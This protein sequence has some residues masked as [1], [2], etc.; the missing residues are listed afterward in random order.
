MKK[1]T[2][3]LLSL[4]LFAGLIPCA[5]RAEAATVKVVTTI[6][7]I[8]D[9]VRQIAGDSG[10][11][12]PVMLL[13]NG[14]DLHSYQPSA[15]DILAISGANLFVYVGGE[16][17]G[18]VEGVLESAMNPSLISVSLTEAMG[19][20]LKEEEIVEGM[21]HEHDHDHDHDHEHEEDEDHDHE[22]E[23][24]DH[25]EHDHDEDHD[26]DHDHEEEEEYDEHVWLSLRNAA[27]LVNA[28]A[29]AL[30]AAD[31][32]GADAYKANADAYTGKL[33]ALDAEYTEAVNAAAYKTLLFGDRFPFR[34]MTDDY[35]LSYYAA[36]TGCSAESEASFETI[37]FLAG[38]VNELNLPA[39][40]TIEGTNHR[41]AETVVATAS[42]P[43][44]KILT[45]NS[46]QSVTAENVKNGA[47][48]LSMMEENLK[49][50]KEALN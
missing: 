2:A 36:F 45:L 22:D 10:R 46:M 38:K 44:R 41:I 28:I 37:A 40:M 4:M 11:V 35:G 5:G 27:K 34:Y 48:Y 47:D 18:W 14:V 13:D 49:V 26:H 25:E 24:H 32:D 8:Y 1:F 39:V 33:L 7:P 20:D 29:D 31:P 50:L 42:D 19:D 15:Q 16:S 23:D 17:D 3:L 9:W 30:A 12:A 21:E 6:F 43:A